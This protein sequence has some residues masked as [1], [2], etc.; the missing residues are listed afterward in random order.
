MNIIRTQKKF[1]SLTRFK[2]I[3]LSYADFSE[4]KIPKKYSDVNREPYY[5]ATRGSGVSIFEKETEFPEKQP[6]KISFYNCENE[7]WVTSRSKKESWEP[8]TD[9]KK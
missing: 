1:L 9:I 2:N 5:K 4:Y 7:S 8:Y 3:F 6:K